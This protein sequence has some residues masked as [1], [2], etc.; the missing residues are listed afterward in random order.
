MYIKKGTP[1]GCDVIKF[2]QPA[3]IKNP[4]RHP[5]PSA[6][7]QASYPRPTKIPVLQRMIWVMGKDPATAGAAAGMTGYGEATNVPEERY[8]GG[9][10]AL[11][12][13]T[14][15]EPDSEQQIA[16]YI[17][18]TLTRKGYLDKKQSISEIWLH[19]CFSANCATT[20][21]T[22][23]PPSHQFISVYGS[24]GLSITYQGISRVVDPNKIGSGSKEEQW[25]W[26]EREIR[27]GGI[28]ADRFESKIVPLL[29]PLGD[30]WE[31]N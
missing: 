18:E 6:H 12:I 20:L 23:I 27:H 19:G 24:K 10:K 11:H 5:G 3:G 17:I 21:K 28:T 30:G 13:I 9:D 8:K 4:S 16:Q 29:Y 7:V 1:M 14:H 31:E 25:E 26:Y 2:R 15:I 22:L